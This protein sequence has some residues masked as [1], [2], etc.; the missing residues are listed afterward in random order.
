M[1]LEFKDTLIEETKCTVCKKKLLVG[2]RIALNL[3]T[4]PMSFACIPCSEA[5]K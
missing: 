4:K 2:D 1:S 5:Q 3:Y